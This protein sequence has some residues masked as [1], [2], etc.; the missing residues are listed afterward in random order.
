MGVNPLWLIL[1]A[2]ASFFVFSGARFI[3]AT[4]IVSGTTLPKNRGSFMSIVS[5]VQQ[6][7]S[8]TASY[9]AGIIVTQTTDGR[10]LNYNIVGYIAIGFTLLSLY[11]SKT[12]KTIEV[13]AHDPATEIISEPVL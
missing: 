9:V 7:T 13:P 3:P 12:L 11:L 5:C 6:L 1:T 2:T 4:A 10:L 8:A